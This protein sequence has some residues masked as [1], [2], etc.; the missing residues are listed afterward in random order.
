MPLTQTDLKNIKALFN[1]RFESIDRRFDGIDR[2][3]ESIDRRF[4]GIDKQFVDVRTDI[5]NLAM[6]AKNQFDIV[7]ARLDTLTEDTAVIKDIVKDHGFRIAR[8]EHRTA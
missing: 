5:D 6:A 7:L 3:F 2:R 1:E 8:L 4:D